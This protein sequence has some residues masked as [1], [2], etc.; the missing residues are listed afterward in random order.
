VRP[1]D[2]VLLRSVYDGRV[3][4]AFPH[5]F[6]L[7]RDGRVGLYCAPGTAGVWMGRDADGRYL[8]RWARGDDPR[9]HVWRRH[10]VLRLVRPA[11][12]HTVEIFWDESWEHVCWYVNLQAPLVETALGF[13]TTDW[14]LDIVAWPGG[15]WRWKDEDDLAEAVERRIFSPELATRIRA[16]GER[17]VAE[18]PWPTGLEHWRPDPAWA[19]PALA[20]DWHV[21]KPGSDP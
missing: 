9:A 2:V 7:E 21:V 19:P 17:V 5:R 15:D 10:H 11:D 14:A 4:W 3:R 18:R 6:A 13:D 20:D 16:A 8:E 12:E 1:G